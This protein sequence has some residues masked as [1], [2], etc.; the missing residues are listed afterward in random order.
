[1]S[2]FDKY[3]FKMVVN[4]LKLIKITSRTNVTKMTYFGMIQGFNEL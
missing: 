3:S 2:A 1:M 4:N